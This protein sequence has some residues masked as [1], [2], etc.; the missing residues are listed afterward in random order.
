M[1]F[2]LDD[3]RHQW[4]HSWYGFWKT[5]GDE[6]DQLPTIADAIDFFGELPDKHEVGLYLANSPIML[7]AMTRSE[8]EFCPE[9]IATLCYH[10]DGRWLWPGSLSHYVRRHSVVLPDALVER[11]RDHNYEP[12]TGDDLP[13]VATPDLPWPEHLARFYARVF[14]PRRGDSD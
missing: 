5:P 13:A 7:S 1:T 2:T 14:S 10:W 3:L 9:Q 11:I 6:T 4:P 12:P 8:C